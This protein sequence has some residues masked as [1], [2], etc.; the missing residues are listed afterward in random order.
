MIPF[1]IGWVGTI[2]HIL[3]VWGIHTLLKYPPMTGVTLYI[4]DSIHDTL[5]QWWVVVGRYV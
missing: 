4:F 1:N 5:Y 2:I 3:K